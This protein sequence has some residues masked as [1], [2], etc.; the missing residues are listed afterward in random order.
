VNLLLDTHALLWWLADDERLGKRTREQISTAQSVAVSAASAWEVAIKSA[1]GKLRA[2]PELERT[3]VSEGFSPLPVTFAH[4]ER[5][6]AL[7]QHHR[8][9]FDRLLVAQAQLEGLTIVT[10]DADIGRYGVPVL[11]A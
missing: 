8:D 4:A 3:V 7:D 5:A 2:P 10:R 6:G 1:L 9:P 11:A